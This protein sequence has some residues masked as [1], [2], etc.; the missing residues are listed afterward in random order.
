V[1][2]ENSRDK[3]KGSSVTQWR[4]LGAGCASLAI[5]AVILIWPNETLAED[6]YPRWFAGFAFVIL[7][8]ILIYM[9]RSSVRKQDNS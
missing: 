1:K 9:A 3:R 4:L 2:P 8:L 6:S 5:S 7:A